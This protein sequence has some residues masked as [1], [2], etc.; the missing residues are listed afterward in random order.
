MGKLGAD[1]YYS[2]G[3]IKDRLGANAAAIELPIGAESEFCGVVN[4]VTMKAYKFDGTPEEN[5]EEIEIPADMVDKANEYRTKL[6]E[7]VVEF[8]D[9]LMENT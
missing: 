5:A 1:F 4:L 8:D 7:S 9:A 3:T 2:L 6:I